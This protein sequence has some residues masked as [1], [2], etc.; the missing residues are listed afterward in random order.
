[1]S[2]NVYIYKLLLE[3]YLE[4]ESGGH[5]IDACLGLIEITKQL[6]NVVEAT[7]SHSV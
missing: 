3:K 2:S 6:S 5:E 4:V 1:M 7:P